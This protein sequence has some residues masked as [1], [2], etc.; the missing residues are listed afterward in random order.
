M[1][2]SPAGAIT[3]TVSPVLWLSRAL[4]IGDSLEIR[5]LRGSCLKRTDDGIGLL[6]AV[7]VDRHLGAELHGVVRRGLLDQH[8]I[9]EV[10]LQ[11]GDAALRSACSSLA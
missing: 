8:R 2:R 7:L 9:A 11:G 4:P 3:R 6:L 10:V 1:L 5:P